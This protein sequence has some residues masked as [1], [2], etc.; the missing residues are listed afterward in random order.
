MYGSGSFDISFFDSAVDRYV[1]NQSLIAT[2]GN[3]RNRFLGGPTSSGKDSA[4]PREPPLLQSARVKRKLKTIVP[5]EPCGIDLPES[6]ENTNVQTPSPD[7]PDEGEDN[8]SRTD[9]NSYRSSAPNDII[10]NVVTDAASVTSARTAPDV[11]SSN[12]GPTYYTYPTCP[13]QLNPALFGTP[14]PMSS[15]VM[16]E[17]D[18]QR[19][20]VGK[21]RRA[22]T[23]VEEADNSSAANLRRSAAAVTGRLAPSVSLRNLQFNLTS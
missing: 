10:L 15:A 1:K 4:L 11:G 13:E 12:M 2:A 19:E 8:S 22:S 21:F 17:Y 7:L 6:I 14:R 23:S 16:A 9:N 18:R 20:K 5:P 3:I